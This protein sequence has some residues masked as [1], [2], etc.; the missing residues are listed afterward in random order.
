MKEGYIFGI[1]EEYQHIF[2][3]DP[4]DE[5]QDYLKDLDKRKKEKEQ[6]EQKERS[7]KRGNMIKS[8]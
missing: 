4:A 7:K 1:K 5:L 3:S 8:G 2:R 6:K